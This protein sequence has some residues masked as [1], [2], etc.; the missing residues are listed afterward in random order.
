MQKDILQKVLGLLNE[1]GWEAGIEKLKR[2]AE[3]ANDADDRAT[4][5]YFVGWMA[6]ER[7]SHPEAMAQLMEVEQ[8]AESPGW[9]GWAKVGQ[10]FVALRQRDFAGT[11][12]LLNE[13]AKHEREGQVPMLRASISHCRGTLLYHQGKSDYVL[14]HLHEALQL[15]GNE[16]FGTGRV[17]DSIGMAYGSRDNFHAAREFFE[18][19]LEH[20]QRYQ[21]S[22]GQALTHGQL[23]RLYLDWGNWRAAR[24]HFKRDLEIS[25]RIDDERGEAQMYNYLGLVSLSQ[26][27]LDTAVAWI[28]QSIHMSARGGWSVLEGYARKDRALLHV[29][30][31]EPSEAD[32]QCDNARD[33]FQGVGF[34]EGLAHVYRVRGIILRAQAGYQESDR[35]LRKALRHFE[36]NGERAEACRTHLEIARTM[37]AEGVP[38]PLLIDALQDALDRAERSRRDALVQ[39]VEAELR[40]VDEAAFYRR[41]YQRARGRGVSAETTSLLAGERDTVTVLFLD[42]QGSTEYARSRDPEVVM[43]TLNQMMAE[44]SEVLERHGV[45]VTAYLGDGFMAIVRGTDHPRRAVNAALHLIGSLKE[46][47]SP[48]EVLGLQPLNVR[49]GISTGEVFVGNVGTYDKMDHTA[50]GTTA[51]LAARL[52]SESDPSQPC[53]S[54]S[55]YQLV[56]EQFVFRQDQPRLV[57]LKGLGSEEA[58]DVVAP[59]MAS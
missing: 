35:Y 36:D 53:V 39:E 25:R 47:N 31:N 51:N 43:M 20:K 37:R 19:A 30:Q 34:A 38:R 50:I 49:I 32:S 23:G 48:R 27:D 40:Q 33:I 45:T 42:V 4:L 54:R 28:N 8:L 11:D 6:G 52:Q 5:H 15:F 29:L 58:W 14:P 26:G 44:F 7:G 22:A 46:F 56:R 55:T 21:D 1:M 18:R 13:A 16:H 57:N 17:L 41:A 3:S 24:E 12:A 10:A 9:R 2:E 59:K